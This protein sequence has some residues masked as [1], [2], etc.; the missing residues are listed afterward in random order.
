MPCVSDIIYVGDGAVFVVG[1]SQHVPELGLCVVWCAAWVG[2]R[3]SNGANPAGRY[4]R[5][6]RAGPGCI[7][8]VT[9]ERR[10]RSWH[11]GWRPTAGSRWSRA[12]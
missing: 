1:V 7:G 2:R 11:S 5:W 3:M 4:A 6:D 9:P 10:R 8:Q 12:P